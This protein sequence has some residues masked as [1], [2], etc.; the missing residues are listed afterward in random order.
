MLCMSCQLGDNVRK[1]RYLESARRK[2]SADHRV[3]VPS[4]RLCRILIPFPSSWQ[5]LTD[6][7]TVR[8]LDRLGLLV[9]RKSKME[10]QKRRAKKGAIM[11]QPSSA[12]KVNIQAGR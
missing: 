9:L 2:G 7:G 8:I 10:S 6:Y 12:W 1:R 3:T 5:R 4:E 11:L